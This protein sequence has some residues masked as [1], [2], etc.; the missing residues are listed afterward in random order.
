MLMPGMERLKGAEGGRERRGVFGTEDRHCHRCLCEVVS[1]V[2]CEGCS[3]ARYCSY[4]CRRAAWEENHRWECP[5][6]AE[7]RALGVMSQL[8]LR[9]ALKAGLK[10][11]QA[12]REPIRG[13]DNGSKPISGRDNPVSSTSTSTD[14]DAGGDP[15]TCYHGDSYQS[16]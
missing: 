7:L 12:A 8:A 6:G 10:D 2:P 11:V 3:Y 9:L 15:F 13:Q 4:R 5:I 16:V 1:P 14:R